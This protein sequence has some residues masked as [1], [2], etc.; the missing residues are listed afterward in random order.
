MFTCTEPSSKKSFPAV[1]SWTP[2]TGT[3][4]HSPKQ[5]FYKTTLFFPRDSV[6][7]N[8]VTDV[9]SL[10]ISFGLE[11]KKCNRG[12]GNGIRESG[13]RN[14][15]HID[16]VGSIMSFRM[17]FPFGENSAQGLWQTMKCKL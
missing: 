9:Y 2:K 7:K 16:D 10:G 8:D 3:R 15:V 4:A 6:N 17:G 1:L 5:P 14:R 11:C 13:V 12:L